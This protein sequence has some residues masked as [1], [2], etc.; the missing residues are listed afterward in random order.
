MFSTSSSSPFLTS[1]LLSSPLLSFP[2]L[3]CPLLP[4]PPL[5]LLFRREGK[6]A[7]PLV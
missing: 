4:S 7:E 5:I 6:K 2:F 3:S 1:P